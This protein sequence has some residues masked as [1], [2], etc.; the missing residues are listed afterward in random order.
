VEEFELSKSNKKLPKPEISN[1]TKENQ[2]ANSAKIGLLVEYS[3]T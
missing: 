2:H 1:A 3:F